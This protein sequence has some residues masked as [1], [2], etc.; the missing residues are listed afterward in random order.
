MTNKPNEE[1]K[2]TTELEQKK[3]DVIRQPFTTISE[4]AAETREN[5]TNT[6]N[7]R[8]TITNE[9][10]S[11]AT[12]KSL[13]FLLGP[14]LKQEFLARRWDSFDVIE[15]LFL[16]CGLPVELPNQEEMQ[17]RLDE[18]LK[19]MINR[20][21]L[22]RQFQSIMKFVNIAKDHGYILKIPTVAFN[23]E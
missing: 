3:S 5:I 12:K 1:D 11:E 16:A 14:T 6:T 15:S 4:I 9:N 13:K 21:Q 19:S 7:K 22:D 8:E 23:Q 20:D 2:K 10:V 17:N 18:E